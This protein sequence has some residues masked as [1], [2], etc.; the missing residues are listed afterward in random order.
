MRAGRAGGKP[1]SPTHVYPT[2]RG[3]LNLTVKAKV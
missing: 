1:V 3:P 2:F